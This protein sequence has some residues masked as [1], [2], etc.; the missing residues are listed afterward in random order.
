MLLITVFNIK[1]LKGINNNIIYILLLMP[2]LWEIRII[3]IS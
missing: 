3:G 1:L 2:F